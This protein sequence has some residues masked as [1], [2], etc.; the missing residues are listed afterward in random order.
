MDRPL[1]YFLKENTHILDVF[2]EHNFLSEDD[3]KLFENVALV[4][5]TSEHIWIYQ[6]LTEI[7]KNVNEHIFNFQI[8]G[9]NEDLH[10]PDKTHAYRM[11][12]DNKERSVIKLNIV[13]CTGPCILRINHGKYH[14]EGRTGTLFIFPSFLWFLIEG[15]SYLV[16]SLSGNHFH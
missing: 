1:L 5:R 2:Y 14:V 4:P 16:S 12:L 10:F 6:K 3:C 11:T 7:C 13:L 9:F 15:D 8:S